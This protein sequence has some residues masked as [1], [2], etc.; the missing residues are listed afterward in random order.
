M[1]IT[2]N[3][4]EIAGSDLFRC[5]ATVLDD[6]NRMAYMESMLFYYEE[7]DDAAAPAVPSRVRKTLTEYMDFKYRLDLNHE[8]PIPDTPELLAY[9]LVDQED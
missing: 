1:R 9:D 6:I 3:V 5:T 2:F 7:G 4:K 8:N